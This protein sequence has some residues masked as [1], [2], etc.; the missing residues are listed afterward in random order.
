MGLARQAHF[1]AA[2]KSGGHPRPLGPPLSR[3]ELKFPNQLVSGSCPT[4]FIKII[5]CLG[6]LFFQLPALKVEISRSK[7]DQLHD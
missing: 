7:G 4:L 2:L 6:C 5:G 1:G 3:A